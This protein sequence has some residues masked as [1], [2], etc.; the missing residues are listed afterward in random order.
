MKKKW[1]V[2]GIILLVVVMIGGSAVGSRNR[3]VEQDEGVTAQWANVETVLQRRF[4]LIPNLI[5]TV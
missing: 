1:I 3:F 4:D 2:P 5:S